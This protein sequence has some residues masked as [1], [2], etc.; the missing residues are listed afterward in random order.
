MA[1]TLRRFGILLTGMVLITGG[2]ILFPGRI[3]PQTN[4][5][6][7]TSFAQA[8]PT[9][10]PNSTP[11]RTISVSGNG[12]AEVVPDLAIVTLGVQ[13]DAETASQALEQNN[14][15]MKAV[16]DTLS[17]AGV[18]ST[19]IQTVYIQLTPRY[20]NPPQQPGQATPA[21]QPVGYTVTNTVQIKVRKLD[22]LGTLLDQVVSAGGNQIQGI[23]FDVS[24]PAKAMDQARQAAMNDATHKATQ[25]ASLANEKLGPVLTINETSQVP[26]PFAAAQAQSAEAAVPVSPGTQTI[27][28]NVQVVWTIQP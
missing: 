12:S 27:T 14:T 17:K 24:N 11:L 15:K 8:Q 6:A 21:N 13:T 9:L 25:L 23:R 28:V 18:A 19:D 5:K 3:Q 26:I 7:N 22:G 2:F 20:E 10:G 1:Q 4:A 16:M